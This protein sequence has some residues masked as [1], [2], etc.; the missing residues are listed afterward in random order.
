MYILI[1]SKHNVVAFY[2]LT[3]SLQIKNKCSLFISLLSK[4][5]MFIWTLSI[6]FLKHDISHF[7]FFDNIVFLHMEAVEAHKH[8]S[9]LIIT[10]QTNLAKLTLKC[11]APMIK[12]EA[13]GAII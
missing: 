10:E 3:L 12:L 13:M 7:I 8:K 9:V 11:T 2:Q 1:F 4:T 5:K 6:Y